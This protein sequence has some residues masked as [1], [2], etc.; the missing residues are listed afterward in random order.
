MRNLI[1]FVFLN[2]DIISQHKVKE[3]ILLRYKIFAIWAHYTG[4]KNKL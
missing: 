3:I 4:K 1:L 2:K